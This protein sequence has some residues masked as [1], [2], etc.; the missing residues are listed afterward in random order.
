MSGRYVSIAIVSMMA[1]PL[2][3]SPVVGEWE[4]DT[5]LS[6]VIGPER[7]ANGDEFG[8]HGYEGV[9]I[10]EQNWVIESCKN[11][12][13][14]QTNA[15]RW[16]EEPISFGINS[17]SIDQETAQ[18]LINSGFQIVGD[19]LPD[20]PEGLIVVQRNGASLEKGVADKKLLESAIEDSLVSIHWRARIDDLRVREDKDVISWLEDQEVWLTTWAEWNL[21]KTSGEATSLSIE[22]NVI[23]STSPP[24]EEWEVPGS[25]SIQLDT[26]VISV[27]GPDGEDFPVFDPGMKKLELGWRESEE[28]ILLTQLPGTSV[29]VILDSPSESITFEPVVTFND[30]HHSITIVGHHTSNLFRWSSDF[31]DSELVFTWLVER[32]ESESIG[33]MIPVIAVTVFIAASASITYLLRK[34]E[35]TGS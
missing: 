35:F 27:F 20:A 25:I 29:T 22:G 19:L 23:T 14:G 32:S 1:I 30:H 6:N 15:S 12:L 7:L 28:G 10:T 34:D 2:L 17:E 5:W 4:T 3:A 9:S 24:S 18:T 26:K 31:Q 16:G 33:W 8:C 11:Y 21:H 13:V